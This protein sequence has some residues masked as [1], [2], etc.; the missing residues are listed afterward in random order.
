[1]SGLKAQQAISRP[2]PAAFNWIDIDQDQAGLQFVERLQQGGRTIP[3]I[4]IDQSALGGQSGV[5]E[6]IDNYP[7]FLEGIGGA[8]LAERF[9]A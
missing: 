6:R 9:I 3:T 7:G 8:D 5:T 1:V 2:A 4:V